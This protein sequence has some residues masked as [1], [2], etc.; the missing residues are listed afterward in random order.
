MI[1]SSSA[2]E[3]RPCKAQGVG[4]NPTSG[5]CPH[6][7]QRMLTR[8][9]VPLSPRQADLFGFVEA[10]TPYGGASMEELRGC[11]A[12]ERPRLRQAYLIKATISGTNERLAETDYR[13]VG[14]GHRPVTYRLIERRS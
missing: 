9:G 8:F 1:R 10:L 13:I 11:W 12:G 6:R 14:D 4:S 5:T 2:A 3:Q 7:G